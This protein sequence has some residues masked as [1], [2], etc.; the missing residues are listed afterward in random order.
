MATCPECG[1]STGWFSEIHPNCAQ[2]VNRADAEAAGHAYNPA[3]EI[4]AGNWIPVQLAPLFGTMNGV[5]TE[6]I[7]RE[8]VKAQS[9]EYETTACFVFLFL[10]L[11]PIARYRVLRSSGGIYTF[12]AEGPLTRS[13]WT[14]PVWW[15]GMIVAA[16]VLLYIFIRS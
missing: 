12:I 11:I 8:N 4:L 5:G 2:A 7:G 9:G 14:R 10:P 16:L 3:Q 15:W 6:L 13:D 1:R